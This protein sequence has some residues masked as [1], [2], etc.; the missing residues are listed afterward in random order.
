MNALNLHPI[1]NSIV[2]AS[3]KCAAKL[4]T[5]LNQATKALLAS[6]FG[7]VSAVVVDFGGGP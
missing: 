3:Q 1:D 5:S 6:V 2:H 7:L 4:V